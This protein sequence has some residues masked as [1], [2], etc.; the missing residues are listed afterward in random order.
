MTTMMKALLHQRPKLPARRRLLF[1]SHVPTTRTPT[2]A[3]RALPNAAAAAVVVIGPW[4]TRDRQP[5]ELSVKRRFASALSN[6]TDDDYTHSGP[7]FDAYYELLKN[8][9]VHEDEHQT[10]A[11]ESLERLRGDLQDYR[12]PKEIVKRNTATT[13]DGSTIRSTFGGWWTRASRAADTVSHATN[14]AQTTQPLGVY[15]HGGVGCGKTFVMNLFYDSITEGPW[16]TQKQKIHFHK[17]MLQVHQE[18]HNARKVANSKE[19]DTIL[20]A[21]IEKMVTKGR[22]ICLDEFQVTDVAD[23]LILQRLFTG[24]WE[25]GCVVVATS[26]RPPDDLYLNGLQRDRFLPFIEL[27]KQKC[28]VLS[29]WDSQIDYRL[30]Q[31]MESGTVP[32]FFVGLNGRREFDELFYEL[33]G[34]G[35]SV[36]PTALETQGRKVKIPLASLSRGVARFNFEDLCQKALGAADY[37]VIGQHFHTVFVENIPN[38]G[39]DQLNWVRRFITFVDSMYESNVKL[40]LHAKTAAHGI[41]QPDTKTEH[42]EVFAFDRTLSR[43][44]E[45]SSETYLKKRW[46]A[47]ATESKAELLSKNKAK[48]SMTAS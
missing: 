29:M 45:M 1:Y 34:S 3:R 48:L 22:L 47:K 40:I 9:E 21:V 5:H 20:P 38:M 25:N 2:T 12:P 19:S 30:I 14:M 15:L 24:L 4:T 32:V 18:M 28:E 39:L 42:D 13:D 44:E 27:L 10:T 33:V 35:R 16:A 7:L 31:K 11:L 46:S 37:L 43:L 8:S 6:Q 23:A 17:F 41:F 26:N 36:M